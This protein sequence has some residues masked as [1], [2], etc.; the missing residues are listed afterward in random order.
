MRERI[1]RLLAQSTL[2][3]G[4]LVVSKLLVLALLPVYTRALTPEEFGVLGLLLTSAA[5]LTGVVALGLGTAL[6]REALLSDRHPRAVFGVTTLAWHTASSLVVGLAIVAAAGPLSA[7]LL[8]DPSHAS[9]IRLTALAALLNVVALA[10]TSML[11]VRERMGTLGLIRVGQFALLAA[12]NLFVLLVL[13]VGVGGLLASEVVVS[14]TALVALVLLARSDLRG[15]PNRDALVRLLRFGVPL[16]PA[17]IFAISLQA[18]DRYV[19][20]A[21]DRATELGLYTM[22]YR[23]GFLLA[24]LVSA[25]QLTWPQAMY[26][27]AR[28][29]DAPRRFGHAYSLVVAA[30]VGIG[31]VLIAAT[32]P[33]ITLLT[34]PEYWPGIGIIPLVV[35]AYVFHGVHAVVG[36]VLYQTGRTGQVAATMGI[37]AAANLGLNLLLVPA[38]GMWGAAEATLAA[39][40]ILLGMTLVLSQR[41]F[42][43]VFEKGRLLRIVGAAAVAWVVSALI[44]GEPGSLRPWVGAAAGTL[45]YPTLLFATGT[46]TKEERAYAMEILLSQR[47]RPEDG[48]G[49]APPHD[50]MP[51]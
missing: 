44:G 25:L 5:V 9:W 40:A 11:R 33:L 21:Y 38:R 42:P 34:P 31:V 36:N 13:R 46:F 45:A 19:L 43:V 17:G 10:P 8:D 27:A 51:K 7:L 49:K 12:L 37:A 22:V 24:V 20:N 26:P 4:A 32:P 30:I 48:G 47:R 41:A 16:V 35:V 1:R 28:E 18:A 14:A 39:Y 29:A 50:R 3:G 15:R 2:Y 6:V 23:F